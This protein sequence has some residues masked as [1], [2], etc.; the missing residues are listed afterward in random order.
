[1]IPRTNVQIQLCSYETCLIHP[2]GEP[3]CEKNADFHK[4]LFEWGKIPESLNRWYKLLPQ[5]V[6]LI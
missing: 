4:D 3:M 1:M 6:W 5:I 2:I